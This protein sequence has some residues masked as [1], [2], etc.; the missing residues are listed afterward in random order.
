MLAGRFVVVIAIALASLGAAAGASAKATPETKLLR[1]INKVR[2]QHGLGTLETSK[3][4]TRSAKRFG[5]KLMRADRFTHA[6]RPQV[7]RRFSTAAEVLGFT[8]GWARRPGKVVRMWLRSAGHRPILLSPD[9]RYVGGTPVRGRF[10]RDRA[11]IWVV[12]FGSM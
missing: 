8:H 7:S 2:A 4:L 10:G 6:A 5:S 1:A 3:S 12:Q 9:Y 11:T